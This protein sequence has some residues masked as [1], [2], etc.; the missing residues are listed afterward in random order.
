MTDEQHAQVVQDNLRLIDRCHDLELELDMCKK[1]L[2]KC[3]RIAERMGDDAHNMIDMGH[4]WIS[5]EHVM[6][7]A[8]K[9]HEAIVDSDTK[10]EEVKP[11]H[12]TTCSAYDL[13]SEEDR[14]TLRWVKD[15][16]GLQVIKNLSDVCDMLRKRVMPDGYEV[17]GRIAKIHGAENI[18]YVDG[19]LYVLIEDSDD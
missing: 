12:M 11:E 19:I 7:Y 13:I 2:G 18:D 10:Q 9:M 3:E 17:D 1:A 16:G 8:R 4:A 14:E 5:A 15:Q 6:V